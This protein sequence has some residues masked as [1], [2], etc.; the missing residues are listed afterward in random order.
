MR[1]RIFFLCKCAVLIVSCIFFAVGCETFKQ[2]QKPKASSKDKINSESAKN[3]EFNFDLPEEIAVA[4][5]LNGVHQK[6]FLE[7]YED[8]VKESFESKRDIKHL[9]MKISEHESSIDKL[10]VAVKIVMDEV[11]KKSGKVNELIIENGKLRKQYA[12]ETSRL[13]DGIG[14][15]KEQIEGLKVKLVKLQISD[16]KSKQ[17]LIKVKTRYMMDKKR[18][19][20][21]NKDIEITRR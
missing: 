2:Y 9:K 3:S 17:D 11:D 20:I 4:V 10:R 16:I 1:K 12:D 6:P 21:K 14:K 19:G 7:R 5:N 13:N 18:W 15:Y 8:I